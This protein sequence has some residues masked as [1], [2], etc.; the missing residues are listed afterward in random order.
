M[1]HNAKTDLHD[2]RASAAVAVSSAAARQQEVVVDSIGG[3]SVLLTAS[4]PFHSHRSDSDTARRQEGI[5][6]IMAPVLFND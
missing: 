6:I 5:P 3:V 4:V 1:A 2:K